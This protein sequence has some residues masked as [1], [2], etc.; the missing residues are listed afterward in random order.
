MM[1][2]L[3]DG[4]LF[5]ALL[6]AFVAFAAVIPMM[7][8]NYENARAACKKDGGVL[9]VQRGQEAVCVQTKG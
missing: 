3:M 4:L 9:I 8:S 2:K 5:G 7:I 1:E 6:F